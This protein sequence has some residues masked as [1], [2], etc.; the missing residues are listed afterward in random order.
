MHLCLF[1]IDG[2]LLLTGGAG[3]RAF[4]ATFL[5][6][7]GV[8]EF[9]GSVLFAGRSDRAILTDLFVAHDIEPSA[10]NFQKFRD[11]YLNRLSDEL[12]Q[13]EG[14]V[15]AGILPLLEE[16]TARSD[17][18]LGL[19]TGNM[20]D[21]AKRK[22]ARYSL[23]HYFE[24]GGFGDQHTD[25]NEIAREA[26]ARGIDWL[27]A[28]NVIRTTTHRVIVVGDTPHDITCARRSA[29]SLSAWPRVGFRPRNS[30]P[31]T[32]I[33]SS[34]VWKTPASSGDFSKREPGRIV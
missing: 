19:V 26:F 27:A 25:R 2:T 6:D 11:G 31:R 24:F 20:E 13:G 5:Q 33:C 10:G 18:A 9:D 4:A 3:Q 15:L 34:R 12:K 32:P 17:A 30:P 23:D 7:F 29:Q 1:D 21:G 8:E 14:R 16:L 22:L 28:R